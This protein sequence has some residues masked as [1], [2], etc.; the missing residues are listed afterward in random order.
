MRHPDMRPPQNRTVAALV[1]ALML[2]TGA[3][4]QSVAEYDVKAAFLFNFAKFIQWPPNTFK[5]PVDPIAICVLGPNPFGAALSDAIKGKAVE[6]RSLS[7][8]QIADDE[9]VS[10][11]HIL[12]VNPSQRKRFQTIAGS[13]KSAAVLT[14][15]E[16]QGFADDGG[17]I[18]FKLDNG[19]VR[20]EINVE[21][22]ERAHLYISSKLLSLAQNVRK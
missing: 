1:A 5:S 3:Q 18:N 21:A 17:I 2:S 12:F 9:P 15:G 6:G 8:R 22:A 20:F 14:V 16:S 10:N 11:C 4:G 13:M 7:L 19:R